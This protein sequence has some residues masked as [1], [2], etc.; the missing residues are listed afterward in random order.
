M[1]YVLHSYETGTF[2]NVEIDE[3]IRKF[4][5]REVIYKKP[6]DKIEV[7]DGAE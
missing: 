5:Y 2:G 3:S 1:H 6:G 4:V 7:F